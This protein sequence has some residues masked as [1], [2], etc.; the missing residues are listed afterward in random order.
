MKSEVCVICNAEISIDKLY[1]HQESKPCIIQ[2]RLKHYYE[3][4]DKLSNQRKLYYEKS[5]DLL[6]AKSR[7]KQQNR[8]YEKK[9][10]NNK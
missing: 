5:R 2:R 1:K 4:K 10:R 3:N 7:L 6:L 9:Y 8:N